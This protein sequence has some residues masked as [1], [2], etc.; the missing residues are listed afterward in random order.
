MKTKTRTVSTTTVLLLEANRQRKS[1]TILNNGTGTLYIREISSG[2]T[3][4]G[5]PIKPDWSVEASIP[6]D[7][8]QK[9]VW[10]YCTA[11]SDIRTIEEFKNVQGGRPNI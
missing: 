5:F 3:T 2:L 4:Q 1:W 8:P 11:S 7:V 10:A 6:E 9:E